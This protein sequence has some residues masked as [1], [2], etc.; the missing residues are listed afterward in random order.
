MSDTG[1][2]KLPTRAQPLGRACELYAIMDGDVLKAIVAKDPNRPQVID[3]T[4]DLARLVFHKAESGA[5]RSSQSRDQ[6][7]LFI[8]VVTPESA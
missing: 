5:C 8:E 3:V 1:E 7:R 2:V 4:D 6:R